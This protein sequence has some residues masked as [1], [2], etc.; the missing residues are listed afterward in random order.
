MSVQSFS[1]WKQKRVSSAYRKYQKGRDENLARPKRTTRKYTTL[2]L[3]KKYIE[4]AKKKTKK[5]FL[6][7]FQHS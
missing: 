5:G 6:D 4:A 7:K 1:N 2:K 3:T